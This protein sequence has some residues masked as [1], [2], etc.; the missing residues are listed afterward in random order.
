MPRARFARMSVGELR[1]ELLR[2]Q[3]TLPQLIARR[4]ALDKQIAGLRALG[5]V[6]A[7][8]KA[9]GRKPAKKRARKIQG[10]TRAARLADKLAEVFQGKKSS[11]LA[12]A[13]FLGD[14]N[15]FGAALGVF[16][17]GPAPK[18]SDETDQER[19]APSTDADASTLH[20]ADGHGKDR[21]VLRVVEDGSKLHLADENGKIVWSQS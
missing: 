4:A 10:R 11:S 5:E 20:L 17:N 3:R 6:E 2:R 13:I 14:K 9:A 7:A 1:S 16:H 8:L 15:R 18:L 12:E 21:A 19:S